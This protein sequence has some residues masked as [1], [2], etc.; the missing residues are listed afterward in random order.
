MKGY[1]V[2][3]ALAFGTD[4][5][6][7]NAD[8]FPFDD[9]TLIRLGHALARWSIDRYGNHPTLLIGHDTRISCERIK[10]SLIAGLTSLPL[11]VVD[12]GVI[13]TPAVLH[14]IKAN[15]AYQFGIVISASHNP[16]YDNGI[17]LFDAITG[18]LQHADEQKIIA[19]FEQTTTIEITP[20]AESTVNTWNEAT[21]RYLKLLLKTVPENFLIGKK[22]VLDCAYGATSWSA[23][24]LLEQLGATVIALAA[25]P[26]GTN[27][28]DQCGAVH[29]EVL[30][31]AV[32]SHHAD[33][34]FA[35]DGD[36][37]RVVAVS[38]QGLIKDGDDFL[39]L[40]LTHP[41]HNNGAAVVGTIM[42]NQGLATYCNRLGKQ[43][44]RSQVG[45]KH[46]AA[47]LDTHCLELGA[48]PSGHVIIRPI[49]NSGDGMLAAL[50]LLYAVVVTHNW[51]LNSFEK[52]PQILVNVPVS[53]KNN[54]T[55]DPYAAI[56]KQFEQQL[57]G[58]RLIVR[59]SG[60]ENKLRVMVED[61]TYDH[62]Y[63]TAHALA[64]SLKKL[65]T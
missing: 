36:G 4:G 16:Y 43:L 46:V 49:L 56:I 22:I 13:P 40:L 17:K 23:P 54:L 62:A 59:Y 41:A 21:D 12:A 20:H 37:D 58:G 50:H 34:G 47:A 26:N 61:D 19:T 48:E 35:F 7:G 53:H 25:T 11:N 29:P 60:T 38:A 65:L 5:I 6:R 30:Q 27:I 3:N 44:I 52:F 14:L 39:A 31:Q 15:H 57:H 8:H 1:A 63:T 2:S 45:D 9:Q 10:Q 42:T 51:E 55:D 24:F 33:I 64:N 18:K 32:I 28:N